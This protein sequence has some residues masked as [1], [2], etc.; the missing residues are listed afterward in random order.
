MGKLKALFLAGTV[1]FG[2]AGSVHAAD[3][4]L[5]PAIEPV[6]VEPI[7]FGGWYLRGDVG[8][9]I[10]SKPDIRSS[11]SDIVPSPSFDEER[12]GDTAFVG[13][14][15]GYQFNHWLRFD[16]TGEYRTSQSI[17]EV[18]SYNAGAFFTPADNSR[19]YDQYTGNVQSSVFLANAYIDIGTWYGITPFIGGGIGG[20][21]NR[22]YGLTDVGVGG[23]GG[24]GNGGFGFAREK[25]SFDLAYA[26]MAGLSYTVSPNLK[27]EIAY[28]YLNMGEANSGQIGCVNTSGCTFE[29]QK[30]RLESQDIKLGMR[31]MFSD[32]APLTP[33]VYSPPPMEAPL[34]RKD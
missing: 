29:T 13:A 33:A 27:L 8:V 15:V 24:F 4:P 20:S 9:G 3:L 22:L 14:G 25:S 10:A 19:A 2:A 1:A 16:A 34:V 5:P 21:Y 11:F 17:N 26:A 31:W 30:L 23:P 6:P 32:V 28:R 18:Q 7:E 12:L